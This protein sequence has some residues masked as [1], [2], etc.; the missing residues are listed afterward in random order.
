MP[1]RTA[2]EPETM[3]GMIEEMPDPTAPAT[4]YQIVRVVSRLFAAYLLLWAISDIVALPH[5]ILGIIQVVGD[6]HRAGTSVSDP[7]RGIFLPHRDALPE[8]ERFPNRSLVHGRW[9][10]LSVRPPHTAIFRG[11]ARILL[12][13]GIERLLNRD[14]VEV[15]FLSL[16]GSFSFGWNPVLRESQRR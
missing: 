10:V 1:L 15:G 3:A 6:A 7:P 16:D 8:R 5:Q 2:G 9:M 14:F 4:H 13:P 12:A 11:L